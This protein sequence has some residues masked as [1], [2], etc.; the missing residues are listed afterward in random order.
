MYSLVRTSHPATGVEHSIYTT[1][2]RPGEKNLIV[3]GANILKV[4]QLVPDNFSKKEV[5]H[6]LKLECV[7]QWSLHG[8][9]QS[10]ASVRLI[11]AL[12]DSLL[13]TFKDAKLSLVEYC[14]DTHDLVT[15]SLHHFEDT[16]TKE[17]FI[18]NEQVPLVRVDPENRCAAMLAYG[19][20]VII[21]PF[22][23]EIST[24]LVEPEASEGDISLEGLR[25]G[26]VGGSK[27][28]PS[29]TIDLAQV[30]HSHSGQHH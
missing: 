9:V 8:W 5:N 11:G 15:I 28:L 7:G 21:L 2:F 14:P 25:I 1:F 24:V 23:R 6:R 18:Q 27:V 3:A 17:G 4:F 22:K 29:Y 19:K 30:I 12:T 13:I 26:G 10:I 20:K 16:A